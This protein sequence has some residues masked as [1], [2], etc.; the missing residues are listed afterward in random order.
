MDKCVSRE[1]WTE[2]GQNIGILLILDP[3]LLKN[4][5]MLI[6]WWNGS[7]GANSFV[8]I[9]EW[10][11][12]WKKWLTYESTDI[13][14]T[15]PKARHVRSWKKVI[16]NATREEPPNNHSH[17]RKDWKVWYGSKFP[18]TGSNQAR[19]KR[20]LFGE[21]T[22]LDDSQSF[23]DQWFSNLRVHQNPLES[24]LKPP[25]LGSIPRVS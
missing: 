16:F 9:F 25:S 13:F 24:L 1:G 15:A 6:W 20:T 10:V 21:L 7:L 3:N 4:L 2:S 11:N 12:E 17:P 5:R 22:G 14:G 23:P 8:Q 18:K 19:L